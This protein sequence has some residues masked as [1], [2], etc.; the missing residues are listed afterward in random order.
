MGPNPRI[1]RKRYQWNSCQ[2]S[3]WDHRQEKFFQKSRVEKEGLNCSRLAQAFPFAYNHGIIRGGNGPSISIFP[4]KASNDTIMSE[5]PLEKRNTWASL[6]GEF[7]PNLTRLVPH[8]N[9]VEVDN[10]IST[11]ANCTS[12]GPTIIVIEFNTERGAHWLEALHF[13]KGATADVIILNEMD[14]GTA[15]TDQQHTTKL[16]AQMLNTNYAWGLEF[17]ELTNGDKEE[18]DRF[19]RT[20]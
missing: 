11:N 13:L 10:S 20:P 7:G 5:I 16:M 17:V 1:A 14:I 9:T 4:T 18:Q 3:K 6:P 15:R 12:N 19:W 8:L 2:I